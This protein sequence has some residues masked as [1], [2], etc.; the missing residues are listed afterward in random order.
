MNDEKRLVLRSVEHGKRASYVRGCRCES[1]TMANRDY[2]RARAGARAPAAWLTKSELVRYDSPAAAPAET[3][4]ARSLRILVD[5]PRPTIR[6]G[7]VTLPARAPL[8]STMAGALEQLVP[9]TRL[10]AKVT[11][12]TCT[13][14]WRI[15]N[16]AKAGAGADA[17]ERARL[18]ACKRC[19][20]GAER[21]E[22]ERM[23][24]P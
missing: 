2:Q 17:V 1:C 23:G 6:A 11:N 14:R 24:E 7:K 19:P 12:R 5:E 18:E 3:P 20:V 15:A 16:R 10:R 22:A 21:L 13:R 8:A 4:A 9:C